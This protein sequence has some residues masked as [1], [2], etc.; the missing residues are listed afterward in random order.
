M[1]EPSVVKRVADRAFHLAAESLDQIERL[2]LAKGGLGPVDMHDG[3]AEEV[4]RDA[5][6]LAGGELGVKMSGRAKARLADDLIWVVS[7]RN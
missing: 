7:H 6:D 4:A 1:A 2:S 5:V 3:Q